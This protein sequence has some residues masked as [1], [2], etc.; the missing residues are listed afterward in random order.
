[1]NC[2]PY[3]AVSG[4][5]DYDLEPAGSAETLFGAVTARTE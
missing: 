3:D 2:V 4:V 5:D 1:M